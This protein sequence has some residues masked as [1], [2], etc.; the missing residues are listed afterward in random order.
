MS[1]RQ[2]APDRDRETPVR[3]QSLDA[4]RHLGRHAMAMH[5]PQCRQMAEET[6]SILEIET[7]PKVLRLR[8]QTVD[9]R[10]PVAPGGDLVAGRLQH[11]PEQTLERYLVAR[12]G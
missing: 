8:P 7:L 5:R 4:L 11:Q 12:D 3:A 9:D 10:P 1:D 2:H 6:S